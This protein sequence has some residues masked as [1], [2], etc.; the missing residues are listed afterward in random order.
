MQAASEIALEEINTAG[1]LLVGG[2][3]YSLELFTA[4]DKCS[5]DEAIAAL[6]KLVTV[7]G[8]D[9]LVGGL[10][11]SAVVAS[12]EV[13]Q[14]EGVPYL[15]TS[16]SSSNIPKQI[17]ANQMNYLFGFSPNEEQVATTTAR[18]VLD[19]FSPR[20]IAL[21][22]DDTDSGRDSDRIFSAYVAANAPSVQIVSHDFIK[23]DAG[24]MLA[25]LSRIKSLEPDVVFAFFTGVS[26][27]VFVQQKQELGLQALVVAAG[28]EFARPDFVQKHRDGTEYALVNVRWTPAF[29][30]DRTRVLMS[31]FEAKVDRPVDFFALQQYDAIGVLAD[32]IKRAGTI[33]ADAVVTALET[34]DIEGVWGRHTVSSLADGHTSP[35]E[36][37]VAQVQDGKHVIVW[38]EEAAEAPV[39]LPDWY[40]P[41]R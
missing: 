16:A 36:M 15:V 1:G 27:E 41:S 9:F 23:Q 17:A 33:E 40:P 30:N 2:T 8:V 28:T 5:P 4:D 29:A 19:G 12:M 24:N 14:R 18:A 21:I 34:T 31:K 38:P 32:A 20:S 13:A 3:K 35:W 39:R 6:E 26:N 25:E 7:D 22:S 37:V 11:S 10:C